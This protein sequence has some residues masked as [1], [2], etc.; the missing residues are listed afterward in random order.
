[1]ND[2]K[3]HYGAKKEGESNYLYK[4]S[5]YKCVFLCYNGIGILMRL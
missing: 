5:M 4:N 2:I 1:M 3:Q